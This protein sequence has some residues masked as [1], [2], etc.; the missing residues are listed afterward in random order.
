[1]FKLYLFYLY[2]TRK[3]WFR[4]KRQLFEAVLAKRKQHFKDRTWCHITSILSQVVK[5]TLPCFLLWKLN[6]CW[7]HQLVQ[8][9]S[10]TQTEKTDLRGNVLFKRHWAMAEVCFSRATGDF[11]LTGTGTFFPFFSCNFFPATIVQCQAFHP[12]LFPLDM[13]PP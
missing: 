13:P 9:Q 3:V 4:E 1:M 11:L 5:S 12:F 7:I 6:K 10:T 8:K 2:F